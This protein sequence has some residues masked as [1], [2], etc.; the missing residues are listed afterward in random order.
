MALPD[1]ILKEA[2]ALI[3]ENRVACLWFLRPDFLPEDPGA[4]SRA[5]TYI[6]RRG[7]LESYIKARRIREWLSQHS[8]KTSA[9]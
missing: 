1:D 8:N 2:H 4:L 6:E 7:D 5:M 3:V 9:G